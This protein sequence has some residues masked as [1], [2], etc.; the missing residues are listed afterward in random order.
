M[1]RIMKFE[2]V[3]QTKFGETDGNCWAA[4][5]ASLFSE[6]DIEDIPYWR[7][8]GWFEKFTE[9]SIA[10]FG[11]VPLIIWAGETL[12]YSWPPNTYYIVSGKSPRGD[13]DH[14]V[15]YRNGKLVHDPYPE[16][17]NPDSP[18][19]TIADYTIFIPM[20]KQERE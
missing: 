20:V 11:Y 17:G 7:G 14:A 12:P 9:W 19:E 16:F 4:C 5:I 13:Y 6:V 8:T 10:E 1:K 18:L 3:M 2:P 15:I